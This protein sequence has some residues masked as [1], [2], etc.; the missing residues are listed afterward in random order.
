MADEQDGKSKVGGIPDDLVVEQAD[1]DPQ[2]VT[3][4]LNTQMVVCDG[5]NG[6]TF[7]NSH[8][9][10]NLF[11]ERLDS[12][13]QMLVRAHNITLVIP[14]NAF[15]PTVQILNEILEALEA[16]EQDLSNG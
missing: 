8:V 10:L 2:F 14:I 12:Q 3:N 13:R 6:A 15:K 5:I 1:L 11:E 16:K 7:S 9:R 4:G